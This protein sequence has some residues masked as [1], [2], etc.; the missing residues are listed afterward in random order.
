[1]KSVNFTE[2]ETRPVLGPAGNKARSM[3]LQKPI[4]KPKFEKAV[5]SQ[6]SDEPEGKMSP[7]AKETEQSSPTMGFKSKN[8]SAAS[9]LRTRQPN[10]SMNAS[11]S[12]DASSDSSHSRASTGRINRQSI[13]P[14]APIRR[15][16]QCGPKNE[17]IERVEKSIGGESEGIVMEGSVAK[18]RC[19]WVTPNTGMLHFTW[20]FDFPS[21]L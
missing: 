8:K 1:M 4:S 10:L 17:K 13:T 5:K 7:A 3:V 12:S 18:K 6:Y 21:L 9:V 14:T 2:S 20:F 19:A 16:Q 15:K 11:C